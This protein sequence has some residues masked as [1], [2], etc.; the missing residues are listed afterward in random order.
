MRTNLNP[1]RKIGMKYSSLT[2]Q[3]TGHKNTESNLYES[4]LERDFIYRSEFSILVEAYYEQPVKIEYEHE[5]KIRHYTPDFL[6]EFFPVDKKII[7]PM[8]CEVKY[9]KDLKENWKDLKPKL[10]A[11][12]K[13]ADKNGWRFKI[14]TEHEIRDEYLENVKFLWPFRFNQTNYSVD[15]HHVHRL[16]RLIEEMVQTTPREIILAGSAD[17]YLQGELLHTLW[18]LIAND[19]IGCDLNRKLT[20]NSEIWYIER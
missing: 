8:L 4:S 3:F 17:K 5:G 7:K 2:G 6:V 14:V 13:Y 9:R 11:G 18:Y 16:H 19:F 12:L 15:F 10:M 1:T 20:M